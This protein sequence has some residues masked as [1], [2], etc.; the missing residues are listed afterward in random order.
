VDWIKTLEGKKTYIAG[1]LMILYGLG[2]EG[3]YAGD[4]ARGIKTALAGFAL[5]GGRS[6]AK[7]IEDLLGDLGGADSKK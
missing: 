7:K 4:W 6:A 1:I 2:V 5:I 3:Y